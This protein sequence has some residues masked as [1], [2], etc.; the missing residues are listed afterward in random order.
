MR[1]G[2]PKNRQPSYTLSRPLSQPERR[3]ITLQDNIRWMGLLASH[4]A[5][6]N[7]YRYTDRRIFETIR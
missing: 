5:V 4:S 3:Y 6:E 7:V 1:E 2:S